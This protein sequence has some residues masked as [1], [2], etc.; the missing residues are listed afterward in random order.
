ML[1]MMYS[2]VNNV[3]WLTLYNVTNLEGDK[4][5]NGLILGV[6]EMLSGIFSGLLITYTSPAFAFQTC[7]IM[8]ILFNALNQ[9]VFAAGSFLSYAT[10]FI[11]ILGVGGVYTCLFVL[12]GVVIPKD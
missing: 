5:V 12:I 9:F 8:G 7:C 11:A 2:G 3:Y 10:L 4:F 6:S 1:I